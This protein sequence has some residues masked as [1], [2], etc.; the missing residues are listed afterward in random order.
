M[1]SPALFTPLRLRDLELA[2]RIVVSPMCQYSAVDG[3]ATDWHTVHLGNL[4]MS[5]A[6]LVFVEAT[7]VEAAGRIT[8]GDHGLYSDDNEAALARVLATVRKWGTARTG[9]QLG[10]AGRKASCALPWEGGKQIALHA[11]GWE[12][13][14]PSAVPFHE[15]DR[16]PAALDDA[17]RARV[18]RAF[19]EAVGRAARLGFDVVEMHNAHGY[20]L[21]EFLSPLSNTRTDAYGGSRENRMRF[22][23][24]VFEAMRAAW[25][26]EKPL[27]VRVSA[28]DWLD[29]GWTLDDTV[30]YARAL[31]ER[32]CDFVDCSSGGSSPKAVVDA[33]PGFQV[34]FAKRVR[35]DT[36][37]ATVAVGMITQPEQ[38][39]A[40]VAAGDADLVALARGMLWDPRWG[41]H[42]AEKLG[43]KVRAP[44]QSLLASRTTLIP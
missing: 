16:A 32:G 39:D 13:C 7:A 9:I 10:H 44:K 5:G 43:V 19:A 22:P 30:A 36:G 3:S 18:K 8:H 21:H 11:G 31:K 15:S 34:P 29:G 37:I 41:W 6:A 25:P 42:A 26:K 2:N 12:T 40:I 33:K 20:L 14:A 28:T 27:G 35:A 23:L 17:G 24:E 4:S 1:T 38:A